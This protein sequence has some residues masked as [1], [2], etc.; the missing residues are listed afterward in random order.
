MGVAEVTPSIMVR[1][2]KY[3]TTEKAIE[4]FFHILERSLR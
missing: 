4:A 1:K 2:Q 3:L